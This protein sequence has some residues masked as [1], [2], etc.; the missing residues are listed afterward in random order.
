MP[1]FFA[2]R[3]MRRPE[4]VG[5]TE[6]V[7]GVFILL[8]VVGIV[9]AFVT[10]VRTNEDYLFDVNDAAGR[11]PAVFAN[12]FPDSG[13]A[14]WRTPREVSRFTPETLYQKINGRADVYLQFHV[15]ELTFGTYYHQTD[16]DRM[17]DVYWYDM[18]KPVNAFGIYRTE[19]PPDA[20]PV[21]IGQDGYKTG[22][23]VFF[24]KGSSYVQVL[25]AGPDMD[26]SGVALSVAGRLAD[27][28]KDGEDD[29][30]AREILPREGRI[31][32]SFSYIAAD[33]FSLGFLSEVFTADYDFDGTRTTLFIHRAAD[34]ASARALLD[35]YMGF[36]EGYGRVIWKDPDALRL[37][38]A[39]DV[40]GMI[41]VVFVKGRYLGG[42]TGAEDAEVARRATV[43]FYEELTVP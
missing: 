42:V 41:D 25:P 5:N 20:T 3:Y 8:L 18:G 19:A 6:K 27:L 26:D 9:T 32:G 23:A 4:A 30:W 2:R 10:H 37:I 1:T 29:M 7:L 15:V 13:V 39:G 28:I 21:S 35:Q 11:Q 38:V 40:A 16:T 34:E 14:G 12:P 24:R 43:A 17:V 33:A 31:A 22:G 36:F